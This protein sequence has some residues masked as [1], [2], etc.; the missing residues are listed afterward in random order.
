MAAPGISDWREQ[1]LQNLKVPVT[2]ENLRFLSAWA[3]AEGGGATNNPFN[4]TQVVGSANNYNNLGGGIGV[5]NYQSPEVGIQATVNTL[6]NGR[7]GN[8]IGALQKGDNAMAAA[9]AL[10]ASPW[11]TGA[12]VEKVL[13]GGYSTPADSS[14]PNTGG[15]PN[16]G[17][18]AG[19]AGSGNLAS[20][21]SNPTLGVPAPPKIPQLG[22]VKLNTSPLSNFTSLYNMSNPSPTTTRLLARL[23]APATSALSANQA[24]AQQDYTAMDTP[25]A[26][27]KVPVVKTLGTLTT[28]SK[29]VP[30]VDVGQDFTG[31]LHVNAAPIVK[32]AQSYLGTPYLWG[33]A[34]PRKGFDCSGFVQYLYGKAGVAIGRTTYD[35]YK[36]GKAI[37]NPNQL[38]PGDVVFFQ[39]HGDVHH[40]GLYIGGGQF[41]HAP[42]T[43][44]VVKISSLS[45]PY[46]QQEFAGGRRFITTPE[47]PTHSQP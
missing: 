8:I 43:G 3:Q 23:G 14:Y 7:Y 1:I 17:S 22:Q 24:A 38:Q 12:L 39:D 26:S 27:M 21:F 2:N 31:D 4:T 9:Q 10:A 28:G 46:Y 34:D 20:L 40:E 19:Q 41:I 15:Q 42:H 30:S 35:Q 32:M 37:Q 13:G 25:M 44:D 5:Q 11:G 33:G 6:T 36:Q 18:G 16:T 47:A 45:D 29:A